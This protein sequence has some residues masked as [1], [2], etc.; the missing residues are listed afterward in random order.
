[1]VFFSLEKIVGALDGIFDIDD[2]MHEAGEDERGSV[3]F[4]DDGV[5]LLIEFLCELF[6]V[7]S[8]SLKELI[9][10]MLIHRFKYL[11]KFYI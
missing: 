1:M 8:D 2:V 11:G 5:E 10:F 7:F 6:F 3:S 4:D 9:L